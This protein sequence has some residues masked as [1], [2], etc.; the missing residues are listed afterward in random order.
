V[1]E[2]ILIVSFGGPEKP[3]DVIPFL[4]NVT[5]GRNIPRERLLSVAGHYY[6]L[7]GK[8]PINDQN[9]ELIAVLR[10]LLEERGP[11]LPIYWGNRNWHPLLPDTVRR[12]QD[13]GVTR[14][15]AFVTSPWGSYSGCR[16]YLENIAAARAAAGPDAPDI[17]KLRLYYN[18]PGF[19]EP[20]ADRVRAAL[21]RAPGAPLVFTAHS[22]PVGMAETSPYVAQLEEAC[23][24][25]AELAK[26]PEH[27]LVYQSRSGPP[28]QAWLE[29]DI[30]DVLREMAA[31]GV[32][33]LVIA[34][35]GFISDNVEVL[36][37][38]D[39]EAAGVARELGVELVRAA[40]VGADPRFV[41]MIRDLVEERRHGTSERPAL[42]VHGPAPDTCRAGCC[43][44][45]GGRPAA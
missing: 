36:Y 30:L 40:T 39:V 18:H 15:Y 32:R 27:R 7:G 3:E 28:G 45:P 11:N 4:E 26:A 44:A 25:V 34:P 24:T 8:S 14:A 29:P 33:R 9:R 12:M 35:I 21:A 16:Q 23:G 17:V 22:V 5:R 6:H 38:L 1:P 43:P 10:R 42:G 2:A 37:D 20:M 19:I 31:A 41:A 13:D